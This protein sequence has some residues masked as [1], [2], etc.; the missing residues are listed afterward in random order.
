MYG[1]PLFRVKVS[2]KHQKVKEFGLLRT[3]P[4]GPDFSNLFS[5]NVL[6]AGI[7]VLIYLFSRKKKLYSMKWK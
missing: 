1:R 5:K 6:T 2:L 7:L 3:S 4:F